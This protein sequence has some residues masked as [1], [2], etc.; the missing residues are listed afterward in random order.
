MKIVEIVSTMYIPDV[1]CCMFNGN[2]SFLQV[3]VAD[4]DEDQSN[5]VSY[6]RRPGMERASRV[7]FQSLSRSNSPTRS[8]S[9][10]RSVSPSYNSL[11]RARPYVKPVPPQINYRSSTLPSR[12]PPQYNDVLDGR[13]V[14]SLS[15]T[16]SKEFRTAPMKSSPALN[17][18]PM[19]GIDPNWELRSSQNTN[20][21][22]MSSETTASV[23]SET[24]SDVIYQG[25]LT[26][27][28]QQNGS[29]QAQRSM[30]QVRLI[31]MQKISTRS[32]AN[33][34]GDN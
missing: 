21:N 24:D 31:V 2:I 34:D 29:F 16:Q 5:L 32:T 4:M 33:K 27:K 26:L 22:T 12:P 6:T 18:R 19:A 10:A 14:S 7:A 1:L 8:V 11:P 20:T 15:Q 17:H 25:T 3:T 9:P 30:Y 13:G 23:H 28:R